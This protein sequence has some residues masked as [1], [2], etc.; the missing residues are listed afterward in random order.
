MSPDLPG[1]VACDPVPAVSP[2]V[3]ALLHHAFA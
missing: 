2:F 1:F 3:N